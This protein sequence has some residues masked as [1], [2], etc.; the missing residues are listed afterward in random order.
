MDPLSRLRAAVFECPEPTDSPLFEKLLAAEAAVLDPSPGPRLANNGVLWE[1][2]SAPQKSHRGVAMGPQTTGLTV[3]AR[4][5]MAQVPT[6]IVHLLDETQHPLISLQVQNGRSTIARIRLTS[7][8]EDYSAHAVDTIEIPPGQ[9]A[10]LHQLPTFFPE[11]LASLGEICRASLHIQLDDLDGATEQERTFPI[12]MLARTSALLHV[13]DPAS[14][15]PRDLKPYLAAWVTPSLPAV[16]ELLRQV[17]THVPESAI[18]SYPFDAT[19]TEA[20]VKAVYRVLQLVDIAYVNSALCFGA[21][22]GVLA[23]RIRLPR[24]SLAQRSANCI[25]GTVLFASL[26]EAASLH[27][28][29][30]VIPG[31]TFLAWETRDNSGTWDYLETVLLGSQSF[32]RAQAQGR[33]LAEKYQGIATLRPSAFTLLPLRTLR[34][35]GLWPME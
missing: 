23:Q 18:T 32:A 16:F 8:V 22:P 12:W 27:P 21:L 6:S 15:L 24:E 3:T 7:F 34:K 1:T 30:V 28:G 9:A 4:L 20:Y 17:A 33:K 13:L 5:R 29:I 10:E 14:G 31:H 26:L 25:D 19:S 35:Q 11:R 2:S